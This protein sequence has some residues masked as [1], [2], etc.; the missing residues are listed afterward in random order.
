MDGT[1]NT[2]SNNSDTPMRAGSRGTTGCIAHVATGPVG[3][4]APKVV[5]EILYQDAPRALEWLSAAFGLRRGEVVPGPDE[6]VLH[7]EMHHGGATVMPTSPTH[8]IGLG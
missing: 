8:D 6:T 5:P 1:S 4:T 3:A 7:A 2:R